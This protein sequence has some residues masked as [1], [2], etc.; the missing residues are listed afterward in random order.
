M[1]VF[2]RRYGFLPDSEQGKNTSRV[3]VRARVRLDELWEPTFVLR[4]L[5]ATTSGPIPIRKV[6][7]PGLTVVMR[8]NEDPLVEVG[9]SPRSDDQ[10]ADA[11][12]IRR[13]LRTRGIRT[14][15]S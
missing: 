14:A 11:R 7:P 10:D 3:Y 15:S 13:I 12:E 1:E 9:C 8:L 6:S 4:N 2:E 5:L